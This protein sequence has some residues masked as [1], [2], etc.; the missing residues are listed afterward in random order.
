MTFTILSDSEERELYRL[1]RFYWREA[2]RCQQARAYLAG[3]VMAASALEALLI[4]MVNVYADEVET[5]GVAPVKK[6]QSR[7]LVDWNLSELIKVAK[8]TKWFP[9]SLDPKED[10]NGRKAK[11]GD[12]AEVARMIRNL[13][14]PGCYL[15]EHSPNRVTAKY[16]HRQ[17]EILSSCR[18]WLEKHNSDKFLE[19]LKQ[20]GL[21]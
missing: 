7:P 5:S 14:H 11:I 3:S 6:G 19:H 13:V 1:L 2:E 10:W 16:L 15:R 17:L 4:A 8:T 9:F 21:L 12:Y 18:D 20:D